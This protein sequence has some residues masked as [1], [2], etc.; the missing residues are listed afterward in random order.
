MFC[1]AVC[2]GEDQSQV[3]ASSTSQN[4]DISVLWLYI[5]VLLLREILT[6]GNFNRTYFYTFGYLCL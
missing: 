3:S 4:G 5:K 6:F 2:G 1:F